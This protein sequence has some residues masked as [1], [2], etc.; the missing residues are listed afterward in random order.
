[1]KG[2]RAGMVQPQKTDTFLMCSR[3]LPFREITCRANEELSSG[4]M[5]FSWTI[6]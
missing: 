3:F 6:G 4:G 1:M 5:A 2:K